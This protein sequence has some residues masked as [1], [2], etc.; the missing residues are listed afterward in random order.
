MRL[1]LGLLNEV[2]GPGVNGWSDA[3]KYQCIPMFPDNPSSYNK[4]LHEETVVVYSLS[5][6]HHSDEREVVIPLHANFGPASFTKAAIEEHMTPDRT[7][8]SSI[9]HLF[10]SLFKLWMDRLSQGREL[11][12]LPLFMCPLFLMFPN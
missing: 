11:F 2:D 5:C 8:L 6:L 12:C 10:L 3:L 9:I 4:D 7:Y 1:Q